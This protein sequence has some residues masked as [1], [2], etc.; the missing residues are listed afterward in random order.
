MICAGGI[1]SEPD[2]VAALSMGYAGVQMGTRFIA[3]TECSASEAYKRA[4][5]AAQEQDI[6]LSDRIT[7]VPVAVINTP[8]CGASASGRV[9][10]ALDAAPAP[11]KH[12]MRTIYTLRSLWQLKRAS[13]DKRVTRTTGRRARARTVSTPLNRPGKLFGVMPLR[14]GRRNGCCPWVML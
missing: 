4:I 14:R 13:R 11:T 6:V 9:P 1:G 10:G 12:L 2:F 5:V 3:T 8:T 7:G